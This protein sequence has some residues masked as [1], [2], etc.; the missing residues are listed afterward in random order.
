[1]PTSIAPEIIRPK[2]LPAVVGLSRTSIWRLERSG[3]FPKRIRLSAGA[4]GYHR[5]EV[6]EWLAS[7]QTVTEG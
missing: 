5:H 7:R 6:D 2:H 4:V 3:S 1:M